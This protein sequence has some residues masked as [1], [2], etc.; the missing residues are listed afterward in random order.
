MEEE[1][2]EK[3]L[4]DKITIYLAL[5]KAEHQKAAAL[6]LI[7][8]GLEVEEKCPNCNGYGWFNDSEEGGMPVICGKCPYDKTDKKGTGFITRPVTPEE[9]RELIEWACNF[10]GSLEFRLKSGG[11]LRLKAK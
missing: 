10:H 6:D 4:N 11:W 7:M 2:N 5:R 1:L 9:V 3:E 8:E